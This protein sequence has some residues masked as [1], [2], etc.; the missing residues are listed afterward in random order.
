MR[1]FTFLILSLSL[2]FACQNYSAKT[3]ATTPT[4]EAEQM[5]LLQK[6]VYD[7][8]GMAMGLIKDGEVIYTGAHGLQGVGTQAPLTTKS[9]FHMASV[10]KPF[11]A[12][13]IVQLVEKGKVD[14]DEKLTHYLP[15]FKMADEAYKD[16][17][18]RQM[19]SHSSGIPD[20]DDYEWDKPQYDE[21]A[22]ERF[23][24]SVI[25]WD[26]DFVPGA[27]YSYS[28]TA[29]DILA[30]VIAKTSG[31]TF[32]AYMEENIFK[33]VGMVNSTFYKPDVPEA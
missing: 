14:L 5:L 33:P 22:A 25:D 17:T 11:V 13:A 2:F 20:V 23:A 28:N 9:L 29:F 6:E 32:E 15:Y 27:E 30:N 18:I 7:V 24:K 21:G 19:L 26:L 3:T 1:N 31:M 4:V 16:I 10:S 12:T 8:P